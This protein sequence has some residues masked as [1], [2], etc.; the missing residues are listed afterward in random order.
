[1]SVDNKSGQIEWPSV[2]LSIWPVTEGLWLAL[3][4]IVLWKC[5]YIHTELPRED[6]AVTS[7]E[8]LDCEPS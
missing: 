6:G 4:K 7:I 2:Q 1:M 8:D 5:P 3:T